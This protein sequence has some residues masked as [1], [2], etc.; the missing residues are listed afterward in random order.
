AGE[1]SGDLHGAGLA[2]ALR[3][4]IPGVRLIGLGGARMEAEGVRL[5]ATVDDLAV[6]G[7]VEVASRLPYFL[8][9]RRKVFETLA[10]EGVDLVIPI[11]YPGFNLRMAR[12]A[13]KLGI[14]VLYYIAPQV[15]AWHASR[16]RDLA[17]DTDEVAVI[18]PFEEEFLRGAGASAR[19]VGHPLLDLGE[20]ELSRDD[21]LRRWGADP[22]RPV[23][24]LFPGSRPQEV[25]RHLELFNAAAADVVR[26]RPGVQPIIGASRDL[27]PT[28]FSGSPWPLADDP[29]TLLHHATA[30]IVKSGTTTLEAAL[31][32]TPFVVAYRMNPLSYQLARRL[33]E[34]P[35]IAL[36]NLVAEERLAP[37]LVQDA[38]TPEA[39]SAAVL[40]LLEAGS[41]ERRRMVEGLSRVRESLGGPG[42]A[43]RVAELAAGLLAR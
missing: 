17:R 35:H 25:R 26:R 27:D 38:A 23:L 22:A 20:P 16:A 33:V 28:V 15:W 6:M 10:R 5:L 19:F 40:P 31:A 2:R 41:P 21:A 34:V 42:A 7:F 14:P 3:A 1:P 43:A 24:A 18:L 37:E 32:G 11:D 9:L 4:R 8:R 36:A 39:L 13:K 30:A 12:H 29:R